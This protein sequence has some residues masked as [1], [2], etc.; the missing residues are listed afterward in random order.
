MNDDIIVAIATSRLEAAI[1][2]IRLSGKDCIAFV[3]EFFTGKILNKASHTITYGYIKDGEQK[4]DEVLVNIYRGKRTF[5]G[6]EMVE[7][8]CH[9]GVYITQKVLNLCLKKGARMAEHGEFSKRAFLN[10]RI[11]LSQAE[12]ISDLI[13]AK[14]DYAT[15]LALKGIQGNI[16]HFIEDL[17]EDLIQIITQIEVNIDYPEYEDVEELTADSLL[18]KSQSLQKKMNHIIESSKN[19]HLL[20]DGISTV[21]IGKPNVGKSSLLNALLNEDK[22]IVT[23]IAGTT[24]D[25]VEGTIRLDNIILNMIDTAGIRDTDDI[26]E[27]IGVHKS[28]ELIHKADLVLLVIDGSA[29]LSKEDEE[30]L[31]LSKDTQRIIVVNKKDQGHNIDIE[32]ISISAR[33]ND[34]DALIQE[35][36]KRFELGQITAGQEDILANARQIQLLQR[37][38]ES[39][40]N[41]I[42]A[43]KNQ[44][45]TDLIVTD[46]YD[47]W[48]N[49]KEILG[50]RAKEDLLDELF[51]RFC[52]GK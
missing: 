21:I 26:V 17:R 25:I 46:L 36:K 14:N 2:I 5:S 29:P 44:V 37:A 23:D 43:M 49:L 48:E 24:R 32:G 11:D 31:E 6:E 30:L 15:E 47:S 35:I 3:Q 12:A 40:D 22:A 41:A 19:V 8:N 9:G 1:S 7:I 50:E 39:L 38:S 34:I 10:G 42:I 28:K 18:P 27:N 45:P 33:D 16:S 52:I 13:T 20:K 51:K 4:I